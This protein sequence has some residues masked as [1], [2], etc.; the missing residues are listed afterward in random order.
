MS[1]LEPVD[2]LAVKSH[3]CASSSAS[4]SVLKMMY[5]H[6]IYQQRFQS[7]GVSANNHSRFDL[8]CE[9]AKNTDG[10]LHAFA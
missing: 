3:C 10:W 5:L 4:N 6:A 2:I 7:Y 8:P 9:G 1:W